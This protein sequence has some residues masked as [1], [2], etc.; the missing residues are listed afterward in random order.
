MT[1]QQLQYIVALD[2]H[3]HFVRASESCFVAQPT[4]TLQVKKL[5][6]EIG[7]T[8][9]DRSVQPLKPTPMGEKFI[10]NARQILMDVSMLKEMVNKDRN[11]L[12][13][14][15]RIGVIPTMAPYLLPLFL[16]DFTKEH[17]NINLQIKEIQSEQII[18][19]ILNDDLDIGIMATPLNEPKIR[20]ISVF[21]EPFLIYANPNHPILSLEEVKAE[22]IN[23]PG[24][25]LLDKGHCF[26]NQILNLC[27]K[28]ADLS[29]LE[30]VSFESGSIE[31]LKK[32][33]LNVSGYT[34]VPEL[35]IDPKVDPEN[36][37]RF[38][39][40]EPVREVSLVVHHSF[41]KELLLSNLRKSIQRGIPQKFKKTNRFITIEWR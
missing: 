36:I 41:T 7:L 2:T 29:A 18:L 37:R 9:F 30:R 26:R 22:T 16:E 31:T 32:M 8:I 25:W 19:D 4:L 33:I 34:L 10:L 20:E 39:A 1:L 11:Q 3:R 35:A 24:L 5:E 6:D 40:P 28:T 27:N 17:P 23:E 38:S 12:E 14:T 15:Y 21:Y 13:G